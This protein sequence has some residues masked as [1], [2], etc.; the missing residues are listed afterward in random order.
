MD[1]ET[2]KLLAVIGGGATI[3]AAVATAVAH[4]LVAW[5]N[6]RTQ[7]ALAKDADLRIRR[8]RQVDPIIELA[9]DRVALYAELQRMVESRDLAK[10]LGVLGRLKDNRLRLENRWRGTDFGVISAVMSLR[11]T[12]LTCRVAADEWVSLM[13]S[14]TASDDKLK[15]AVGTVKARVEELTYKLADLSEAADRYLVGEGVR[16]YAWPKRWFLRLKSAVS[17]R[18][19]QVPGQRR[20]G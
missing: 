1:A 15:V 8:A 9:H 16:P 20:P 4:V 7:R 10:G 18:L 14:R 12:D 19:S 6:A 5:F 13:R 11:M 17:S 3:A 2:V